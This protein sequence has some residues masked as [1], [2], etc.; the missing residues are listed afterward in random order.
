MKKKALKVVIIFACAVVVAGGILIAR[1]GWRRNPELPPNPVSP[2]PT[3]TP[4]ARVT[5][6]DQPDEVMRGTVQTPVA[7]P[8]QPD[9][10]GL[11][12]SGVVTTA[13]GEPGTGAVVSAYTADTGAVRATAGDDGV[14]RVVGLNPGTFRVSAALEHHNEAVVEGVKAPASNVSLVV[15]PLSAVEG[16]V[17]EGEGKKP[18][19]QFDVLYLKAPPGDDRHWQNIIRDETMKWVPVKNEEG[20]YRIED[21]VSNAEFAVA[22]RADGFEPAYVVVPSIK[23]AETGQAGDIELLAEANIL[24]SVVNQD[25]EPLSGVDI[26]LGKEARGRN[27][28]RSNPDGKFTIAQ[29]PPGPVTLTASHRD[30][31]PATV[32]ATLTRG[33]GTEVEI[34]LGGGGS[35]QGT[36]LDG[37]IPLPHQT[38][39][40]SRL[41]PP[42][43]RKDAITDDDGAY[44]IEGLPPGEVEL[45]AKLQ[46]PGNT[47]PVPVR[48]QKQAVIEEGQVTT[49][50]FQLADASSSIEGLITVGGEPPA[51]A[52]IKG[53]VAG[54]AGDTFFNT[55]AMADGTYSVRN[56]PAGDAWLEVTVKLVEGPVRRKNIPITVPP[57]GT[58]R[59]DIQYDASAVVYGTVS[60]LAEGEGGEVMA[61]MG[62]YSFN[63]AKIDID[64]LER[65]EVGSSSISTDGQYRLAGLDPGAYT[66]IVIVFDPEENMTADSPAIRTAAETVT[67]AGDQELELNLVIN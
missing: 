35:I 7:A 31:L 6:N 22:A 30:H 47:E 51:M 29:M 26:Y 3:P 45:I 49:V 60:T 44:T 19:V 33:E 25:H 17:V 11:V 8:A 40:A 53:Y 21:V 28:A 66:I 24:G 13:A 58:V 32:E 64:E 4:V 9:P 57:A 15:Q 67:V 46:R 27:V 48:L 63:P 55:S 34:V 10:P 12:I 59:Q 23:P 52:I 37:A 61:V 16:K 41:I 1:S 2:A 54:E 14:F 62:P 56:L 39:M 42:R 50:D 5:V 18:L 65:I 36:V 43:A 38:I 20:K